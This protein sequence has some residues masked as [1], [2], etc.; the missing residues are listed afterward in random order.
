[1]K[2]GIF[3][4]SF[5]DLNPSEYID[6]A[7]DVMPW[8]MWLSKLMG[9]ELIC[10]GRSSTSIWHSFENFVKH[11]DE[12]DTI[13]FAYTSYVRLNGLSDTYS[14]YSTIMPGY[15]AFIKDPDGVAK[16][17]CDARK[18]LHNEELQKFIYRKVFE[19]VNSLCKIH[20]KKL[21]NLLSFE[22]MNKN[23]VTNITNRVR[24]DYVVDFSKTQYPCLVSLF[25]VSAWETYIN[26]E[27][28]NAHPD[29]R[30]CHM[31]PKNNQVLAEIVLETFDKPNDYLYDLFLDKRF[32]YE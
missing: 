16:I 3:G 11:F 20:N 8:P 15:E 10:T 7:N 26:P 6:E 32:V 2:L 19:E 22:G 23:Y 29:K 18:Y 27:L 31:S 13:V 14:G 21:V 25:D 12:C 1:M 5:A 4:D 17:I 28:N 24:E 30:H 9:K